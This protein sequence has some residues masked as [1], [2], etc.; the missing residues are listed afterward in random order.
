M[1]G[2]RP[3]D[4]SKLAKSPK[5]DNDVIIF[6]HDVTSNF[7]TLFCFSCQVHVNIITGSG[8]SEIRNTHAWVFPKYG[9]W[10]ELWIPNL[11]RISLI[12]CH[13]M[14]QNSRV[15]AFNVFY[16]LRENHRGGGGTFNPPTHPD[17]GLFH[18]FCCSLTCRS[19]PEIIYSIADY[20]NFRDSFLYYETSLLSRK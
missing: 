1:S 11:V 12:E 15:T 2:I 3:S 7:L 18:N 16:F 13:W 19:T 9:D 8:K 10:G 14:L 5:N 6:R 20:D 17:S 4:C